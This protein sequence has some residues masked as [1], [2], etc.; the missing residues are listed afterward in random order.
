[1]FEKLGNLKNLMK[2]AGQ[3]GQRMKEAH[4]ALGD[5]RVEASVGAGLVSVTA[6]GRGELIEV[7][8]DPELLKPEERE[9]LQ[10]LLLSAVNETGRKARELAKAEM[11]NLTGGLDIGQIL[12]SS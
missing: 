5:K 9:T 6:N 12:G 2:H 3:M 8:I 7:T 10:E 11:S 4:D 1:M